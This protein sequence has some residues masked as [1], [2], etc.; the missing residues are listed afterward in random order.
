[1]P[2]NLTPQYM[3]ADRKFK[4]ATT[5]QQ[6]LEALEEMLATIP[7]HK[8]TEKMQADLKRRI[9][10]FRQEAQK[11]K[12]T[13]RARPFYHVEREGAGQIALVGAPNTGKSSLLAALTNA[14]PEVGDYPFTTRVPL[15]GMAPFEDVQ[16]QLV[17][18]P[19]VSPE[20]TE[21]WFYAIIRGADGALVVVDLADPDIL[22]STEQVFQLLDAGGV[23]LIPAGQVRGSPR[24]V[25]AA[26]I[27][28]KL[29]VH[30]AADTLGIFKE[31]Y[32]S[33][34]PV[35]PVS[36]AQDVNLQELRR[37][38]FDMLHVIR[39]YSKKPG[40]KADTQAPYIMKRGTQV[41]EAA[42]VV[43][44]DFVQTLKYARLWRRG[45]IEGQMVSRE[46]VLEDGDILEL[47]T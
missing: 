24:E 30:G 34:L 10:K 14:E 36:A 40:K 29:D 44:K 31:F 18:L 35:L 13:S 2:A 38:V 47:H 25:P 4:Q 42:A 22:A 33:R 26:F 6:K 15:A 7:K 43:H 20:M 11:R 27:A 28:A 41:L 21:G 39:V 3:E 17:D 1:M 45:H 5:P 23:E 9:A 37:T 19:P 16:I 12:G 32:G 8:G 46:Q